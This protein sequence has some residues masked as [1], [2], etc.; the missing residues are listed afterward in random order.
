MIFISV[1]I[2]A[3]TIFDQEIIDSVPT[4]HEELKVEFQDDKK[5]AWKSKNNIYIWKQIVIYKFIQLKLTILECG[6]SKSEREL[7]TVKQV[8]G[9]DTD[10]DKVGVTSKV[11]IVYINFCSIIGQNQAR[12]KFLW[13]LL[14]VEPTWFYVVY[15]NL[16]PTLG[17]AMGVEGVYP[18]MWEVKVGSGPR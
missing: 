3:A 15:P 18:S 1:T 9:T 4:N 7:E 12:V 2:D 5:S 17:V 8:V 6:K 13:K 16:D 11:Y 10:I 14:F